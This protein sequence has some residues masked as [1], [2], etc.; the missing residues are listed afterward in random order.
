MATALNYSEV[1]NPVGR[2]LVYNPGVRF[3]RN[4]GGQTYH[5]PSKSEKY[6]DLLRELRSDGMGGVRHVSREELAYLDT[7][8]NG[9]RPITDTVVPVHTEDPN[10]TGQQIFPAREILTVLLGDSGRDGMMGTWGVR[11]LFGDQRDSLVVAEA[12]KKHQEKLYAHA[13]AATTAHKKQNEKHKD[14]GIAPAPPTPELMRLYRVVAEA[15][16][17]GI[18]GVP[19]DICYLPTPDKDALDKHKAEFHA[20]EFAKAPDP[21]EV[22]EDAETPAEV[23]GRNRRARNAVHA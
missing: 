11:P 3:E 8:P 12:N 18:S 23:Q 16:R 6:S 19:C 2:R 15:D 13:L 5:F 1:L 4:I 17:G 10:H 9:V 21:V 14:A 7:L 22:V 20:I